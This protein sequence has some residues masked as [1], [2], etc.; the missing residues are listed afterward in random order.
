MPVNKYNLYSDCIGY[1][2]HSVPFEVRVL[3][4]LDILI[5]VT[6][7]PTLQLQACLQV[8]ASLK[9]KCSSATFGLKRTPYKC[10]VVQLL[11]VPLY[12]ISVTHGLC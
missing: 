7:F 5:I 4:L 3:V 9:Q 6:E 10:Y 2:I 1:A 8:D 12:C 11:R